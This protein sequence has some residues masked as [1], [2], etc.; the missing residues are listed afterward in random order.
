MKKYLILFLL[1]IFTPCAF[2]TNFIRN[3]VTYH[4][5]KGSKMKQ[6]VRTKY[7]KNGEAKKMK[8]TSDIKGWE[9]V[10]A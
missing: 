1:L 6:K 3:D 5:N 9:E 7:Y 8:L 4:T 10:N 2:A